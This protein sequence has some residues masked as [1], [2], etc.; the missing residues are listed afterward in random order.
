MAATKGLWEFLRSAAEF[1]DGELAGG[2]ASQATDRLHKPLAAMLAIPEADV[3]CVYV[4]NIVQ[5]TTPF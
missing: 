4:G 3:R 2:T 1:K 5:T